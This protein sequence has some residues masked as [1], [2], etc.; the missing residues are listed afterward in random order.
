VKWSGSSETGSRCRNGCAVHSSLYIHL[1]FCRSKC[2]YCD[3]H[4]IAAHDELIDGYLDAVAR[5]WELR[6]GDTPVELTSIYIGGG[7][8]SL[9]SAAQWERF[10]S[11]LL[12]K[13]PLSA[14]VE[15]TVECNP[16]SFTEE[17][18]HLLADTGVNRLTFG[19][20]SMNDRELATAGRPHR[21][22]EALETLESDVLNRFRS[23]G[24]DVIYGLPGQT[25]T[26]FSDTLHLL[27]GMP[28]V[29]HLSAY[30]LTLA[31][32]TPFGKHRSLLPF[33]PE[34]AL[35]DMVDEV[36]A[37]TERYG[38]R[39]YEVS[40]FAR[41][42]YECR[43]NIGYWNHAPCIGIGC[44]AHSYRHP[45][46]SWNVADISGYCRSLDEGTLPVE[47]EERITPPMMAH[48]MLFLGLR[49]AGGIDERLFEEKTGIPFTGQAAKDKL[50][51]FR[52]RHLLEYI[53]PFWKPTKKG[54][55][56]ADFM[57]RELF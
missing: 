46:R 55:F 42:G 2:R 28:V 48:E 35:E 16:E 57:A 44:A 51:Q 6:T 13:L 21:S 20:Q 32:E 25:P 37:V 39:H 15:W 8:P 47:R 50:E 49:Q 40:N 38:L 26:S 36:A 41:S 19:I 33:P 24:V 9:L 4:S 14:N 53:P 17:K 10:R 45:V 3:F 54:L 43:H 1:P 22:H 12:G 31:P 5:E 52:T 34:E 11:L 7:T 56:F 27:L 18:A 29:K 23:V 30:E